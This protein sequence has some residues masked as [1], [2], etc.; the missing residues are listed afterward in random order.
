M[1]KLPDPSLVSSSLQVIRILY[2]KVNEL[3]DAVN[4]PRSTGPTPADLKIEA[5]ERA[6]RTLTVRL[7]GLEREVRLQRRHNHG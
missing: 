7:E 6:V 1:Q 2:G 4:S 3:V 5:L